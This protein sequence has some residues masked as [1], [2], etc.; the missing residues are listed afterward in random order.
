MGLSLSHWKSWLPV[1]AKGALAAVAL[2]Y[3]VYAVDPGALIRSFRGADPASAALAAALLPLNLALDAWVWGVLLRPVTGRVGLARLCAATL[4]GFALGFF[5][6]A[7]VGEYPGRA[8]YLREGD[9]WTVTAT[10][11]A[12]RM[13]DMACAVL[14]GLAALV[15]ALATGILPASLPWLAAAGAGGAVGIVL[16]GGL[17]VPS[18]VDALGR[19][20]APGADGLHRRTAFLRRLDGAL[21]ARVAAGSAARY[22]VFAGQLVVL[23]LAF[24]P[25]APLGPLALAAGLTFY[26][27]F[28]VPSFT[29]MDLGIREGAA[30]FFFGALGLPEAA[31]LNAALA[32][33]VLNLAVPSALGIPFLWGLSLPAPSS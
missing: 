31:G 25:A 12:Q 6:P 24:A 8:F 17:A 32:L 18:A 29:L 23:G 5:T 33:F 10:I 13:A 4:S 1:V 27:K 28:L 14:A 11:F 15:G 20:L 21:A 19:R 22:L 9:T 26:V 7:R 16:A 2:A 30:V 3:L